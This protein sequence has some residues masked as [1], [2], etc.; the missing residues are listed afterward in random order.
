MPAASWPRR[1]PRSSLPRSVRACAPSVSTARAIGAA[2]SPRGQPDLVSLRRLCVLDGW[3]PDGPLVLRGD[4]AH[5]VAS[6][7][8]LRAGATLHVFD[9]AGSERRASIE[10]ITRAEVTLRL[11]EAVE[12]LA[13][14]R[15]PVTLACAFPRGQR[16]DWV[17]EKA[18]ELGAAQI[19]P[20]EAERAVLAP[21][22]GR[23]ERWRR[24]AVEAAEQCGRATLPVLG[25]ALPEDACGFVADPAAALPLGEA[26]AD[27][28][29]SPAAVLYV[30]PEGGWSDQERARFRADGARFVSLGLRTLRVETAA[31][32]G[33]ARLIEA[34]EGGSPAS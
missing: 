27:A 31:V 6:V 32:A 1:R 24:I 28:H 12:A 11:H 34:L 33:L 10:Q 2:S 29:D 4:E 30:G 8:R 23:L 5:R 19:V 21:G 25:G 13:E 16:G 15:V 26:A 9:G 20:L 3:P 7:W 14:C 22:D 17:V 18:T